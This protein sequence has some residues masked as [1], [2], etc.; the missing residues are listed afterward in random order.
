MDGMRFLLWVELIYNYGFNYQDN[1][2]EYFCSINYDTVD[3]W[4]NF[5]EISSN[6]KFNNELEWRAGSFVE[7]IV[8]GLVLESWDAIQAVNPLEGFA[9]DRRWTI[10]F[11]YTLADPSDE[12]QAHQSDIEI[13]TY[14]VAD[15]YVF[16]QLFDLLVNQVQAQLAE[17]EIENSL[18]SQDLGYGEF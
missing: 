4:M 2:Q 6:P 7:D 13:V 15:S 11:G 9:A 3:G 8:E 16:R 1:T 17:A 5:D 12:M 10:N 18:F 14:Y